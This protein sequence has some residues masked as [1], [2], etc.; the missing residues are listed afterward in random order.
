MFHYRAL[1]ILTAV[2]EHELDTQRLNKRESGKSL[3]QS[4]SIEDVFLHQPFPYDGGTDK[5]TKSHLHCS[6]WTGSIRTFAAYNYI[7]CQ[8]STSPPTKSLFIRPTDIL[9]TRVAVVPQ[10]R[11]HN[12]FIDIIRSINPEVLETLRNRVRDTDS[13]WGHCIRFIPDR[14]TKILCMSIKLQMNYISIPARVRVLDVIPTPSGLMPSQSSSSSSTVTT[15]CD[16]D[17]S[18]AMGSAGFLSYI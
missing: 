7:Y 17:L 6:A 8:E 3:C 11:C 10:R 12:K 18:I 4:K 13:I 16:H 9:K 5:I 1:L 2:H 14:E 15:Y